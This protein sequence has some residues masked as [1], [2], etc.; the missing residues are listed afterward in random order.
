MRYR[1]AGVAAL[2]SAAIAVVVAVV[3]IFRDPASDAAQRAIWTAS[4]LVVGALVFLSV[5]VFRLSNLKGLSRVER[6]MK[7]AQAVW[8]GP[9]GGITTLWELTGPDPT[10]PLS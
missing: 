1:V 5:L 6:R 4:G 3:A 9:I 8:G 2:A 7:L 10:E